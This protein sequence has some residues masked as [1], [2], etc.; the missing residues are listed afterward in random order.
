M[1]RKQVAAAR[2]P[3]RIIKKVECQTEIQQLFRDLMCQ[4]LQVFSK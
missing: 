2:R 3:D 1:N 4:N